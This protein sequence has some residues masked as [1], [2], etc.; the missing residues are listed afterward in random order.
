MNKEKRIKNHDVEQPIP[1]FLFGRGTTVVKITDSIPSPST[2]HRDLLD[3]FSYSVSSRNA[4][5]ILHF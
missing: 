2:V 4:A 1:D 3:L 5:K